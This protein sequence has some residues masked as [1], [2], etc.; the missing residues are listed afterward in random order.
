MQHSLNKI[1]SKPADYIKCKC[2][3]INWYENSRCIVCNSKLPKQVMSDNDMLKFE[4]VELDSWSE[5]GYSEKEALTI[6][7][8][9]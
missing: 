6:K 2:S 3:Q 7:Y 1:I 9:I 4:K 5:N 8:D